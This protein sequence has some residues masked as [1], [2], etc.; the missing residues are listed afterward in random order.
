[1]NYPPNVYVNSIIDK[2]FKNF[3]QN[4]K[5]Q[6]KEKGPSDPFHF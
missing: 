2:N 4:A 5:K 6:Q 3:K 1:M